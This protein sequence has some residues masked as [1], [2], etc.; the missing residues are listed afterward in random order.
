MGEL[1]VRRRC[2]RRRRHLEIE[3]DMQARELY[4]EFSLMEMKP[5]EAF[6]DI[7]TGVLHRISIRIKW[8]E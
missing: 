1:L 6:S 2:C 4:L 5:G 8:A 7:E 3:V